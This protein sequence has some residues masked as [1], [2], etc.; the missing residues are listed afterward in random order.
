MKWSFPSKAIVAVACASFAKAQAAWR[1][2]AP[3][4]D[5]S[6]TLAP[7]KDGMVE[8]GVGVVIP[9]ARPAAA[10]TVWP[11]AFTVEISTKS[12]PGMR[13]RVPFRVAPYVIPSALE[14]VDELLIVSQPVTADS[15]R[16]VRAFAA[17]TGLKLVA[18][19]V[20]EMCDQWMQD[21][22]EPGLFAFPTAEGSSQAR[23]CL[24]GLRKGS[25]SSAAR[26]DQQVATWLRREGVVTVAP[27]I[28][29]KTSALE[30]LVRQ[31]RSHASAHRPPGAKISLRPGDHRKAHE[32]TMHPGVLKFLEAQGLQWPP[33]VV[34]T[35][36]LAIGHVD[37]VV[38][39]VP[40]K[41][42][43][44]FKVLCPAP[45]RLERCSSASG[46]R[47]GRRAGFCGDGRRDDA[48]RTA[49]ED[50]PDNGEPGDRRG[51]R[52]PPRAIEDGIES[53]GFRLS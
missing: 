23:A 20:D 51:G 12:E 27:G 15:V 43:A 25:G 38:N 48:R 46:E 2:Q 24:S 50:R 53:G 6:W 1:R 19:E 39:F 42:K 9:D 13:L 31:R 44:G 7:G 4:E 52:P 16:S 8:V 10:Q 28:P 36:W 35:S 37:E 26:L 5:N 17:R 22:I 29:R 49:D 40:A 34:D 30:R 41:N 3:S 21:T 47:V 14:P 33:I 32:L 45:R 18:H 11:R